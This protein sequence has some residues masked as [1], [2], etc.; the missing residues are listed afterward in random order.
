MLVC[1]RAKGESELQGF[2]ERERGK[3]DPG[4]SPVRVCCEGKRLAPAIRDKQGWT[5]VSLSLSHSCSRRP[6][7]ARLI[8]RAEG[9]RKREG[10]RSRVA[11]LSLSLS[12]ADRM[13]QG[14]AEGERELA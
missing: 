4:D 2:K 8:A 1:V 13:P 3:H 14:A 10:I 5:A 11:C 12:A 6:L 9:R 7:D